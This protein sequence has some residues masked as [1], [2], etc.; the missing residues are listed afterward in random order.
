[1]SI[2]AFNGVVESFTKLFISFNL[3]LYSDLLAGSC[4]YKWFDQADRGE[5]A[6]F[7]LFS[8]ILMGGSRGVLLRQGELTFSHNDTA[9]RVLISDR[10]ASPDFL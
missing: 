4:D 6:V 2:L 5:C 8:G 9:G 3:H 10:I 1:M 7:S